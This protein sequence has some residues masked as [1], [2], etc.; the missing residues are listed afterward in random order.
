VLIDYTRPEAVKANVR[1]AIAA[2]CHV[3]IGTSGLS[4]ADYGE[5]DGWAK[6]KGVS[7]FAAGNFSVTA[8]LMQHFAA[9][10]AAHMPHWELV[11][12]A[13]DAKP[14][15]PSGT[16]R[17][18][19]YQLVEVAAPTWAVPVAATQGLK[20]SRG[21]SLNGSQVHSIRVPGYYSAVQAIFG[22]AG[23]RIELRH[24]STSYA[25]YVAGTLL[26]VRKA[27]SFKGLRRGMKTLLE[28]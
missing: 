21:A 17:E 22:D 20:E 6:A 10:A 2:G 13:S 24:E 9:V 19:S 18:L 5:I 8:A 25:P 16:A 28:L 27:G 1:A 15:A 3:V 11:D 26:A 14:D 7:A 23:E 12:Y 4:D